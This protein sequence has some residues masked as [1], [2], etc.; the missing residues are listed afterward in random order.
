MESLEALPVQLLEVQQGRP[1]EP[2]LE[3]LP[4]QRQEPPAE[5]RP[6]FRPEPRLAA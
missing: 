5:F 2:R 3:Q 1:Q 6:A 4:E